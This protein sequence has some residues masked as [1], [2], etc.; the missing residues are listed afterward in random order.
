MKKKNHKQN[1]HHCIL[2]YRISHDQVPAFRTT[3]LLLWG[4]GWT[5]GK[6]RVQKEGAGRRERTGRGGDVKKSDKIKKE[7]ELRLPSHQI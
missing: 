7:G 6:R 3:Q 1:T 5:G 4:E 2:P